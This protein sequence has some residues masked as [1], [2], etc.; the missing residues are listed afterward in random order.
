MELWEQYHD[1]V[2]TIKRS[3]LA[4][5][6]DSSFARADKNAKGYSP[7][8][9]NRIPD[10][11][12]LLMRPLSPEDLQ[13][14]A[15]MK[16]DEFVTELQDSVGPYRQIKITYDD[17][18]M[19]FLQGY[20]YFSEDGARPMEKKV[21]SLIRQTFFEAIAEKQIPPFRALKIHLSVSEN[22]DRSWNMLFHLQTSDA[23]NT[24]TFQRVIRET[25]RQVPASPLSDQRIDYLLDMGK[26]MKEKVFG[27][28]QVIDQIARALLLSEEQRQGIFR[29]E[30]AKTKA[31]TFVFLGPSGTGKSELASVIAEEILGDRKKMFKIDCSAIKSID[32]INQLIYG[33]KDSAGAAVASD[34]MKHYK[35]TG[36]KMVVLFDEIANSSPELLKSLYDL[37][38]LPTVS[39]FVD[40][41]ERIM[42]NIIFIQTGNPKKL[43][44]ILRSIPNHGSE[45][46]QQAA[47]AEIHQQLISDS[48]IL[49][50]TLF[51]DHFS[52]AF[53]GRIGEENFFLFNSLDYQPQRELFN[54]K[55]HKMLAAQR[56]TPSTRGWSIKFAGSENYQQFADH[57]SDEAFVVSEQGRSIERFI[58]EKLGAT[59]RYQLLAHKVPSGTEVLLH[60]NPVTNNP[61]N[62]STSIQ[63]EAWPR[64][65][66]RPIII[67]LPRKKRL[68]ELGDDE[69]NKILTGHHEAGHI[70]LGHLLLGDYFTP[71]EVSIMPGVTL[72]NDQFVSFDG[73][74]SNEVTKKLPNTRQ[75]IVR[76]IAIKMGGFIAEQLVATTPIKRAGAANDLKRATAIARQAVGELGFSDEW[77]KIV[78][79]PGTNLSELSAELKTR[80]WEEVDLLLKEGSKLARQLL[81][82]EIDNLQNI[83]IPLIEQGKLNAEQLKSLFSQIDRSNWEQQTLIDLVQAWEEKYPNPPPSTV[84]DLKIQL[85][86]G[87]RVPAK[88]ADFEA[89]LQAEKQ[90]KLANAKNEHLIPH[91]SSEELSSFSLAGGSSCQHLVKAIIP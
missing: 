66:S 78:I 10:E 79:S 44:E 53:I 91:F 41:Q 81:I 5:A 61:A 56:P 40:N 68:P 76:E 33:Y 67:E 28:D 38:D 90:T 36:G 47:R 32:D 4:S 58:Q 60:W 89:I 24:S 20:Q 82:A 57:L 21:R 86:A 70:L 62:K 26:R 16:M 30:D 83:A 72:I 7:E 9:L 12:Y 52:E 8:F 49:R 39:T 74:A 75:Q 84:N 37:I 64:G 46:I 1:D 69:I 29:P 19:R 63:I 88:V 13:K 59:L 23:Q 22:A 51:N 2:E 85:K 15:T 31:R 45:A 6:G 25:L 35:I 18:L 65:E 80:Y 55:M 17:E 54:L 34:F 50:S 71:K 3:M 77:G 27:E 48:R 43:D 14:I 42:S 73:I 11:N 87:I